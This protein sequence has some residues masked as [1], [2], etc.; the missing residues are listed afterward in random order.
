MQDRRAPAR[1]GEVFKQQGQDEGWWASVLA[2]EYKEM[3]VES[4][5]VQPAPQ[6]P[7]SS[8]GNTNWERAQDLFT[9]DEVVRL[10]VYGF[11]HGG[12]LVQGEQI[13]GFVPVSH[14]IDMACSLE[15]D[16]R[17]RALGAYVSR[18]LA[19][20]I[21]ECEPGAERIVLSERAALA[22]E[23]RRRELFSSLHEG[24]IVFGTVTNITDFGVFADLGG[25]EGLIHV[26]ELSWGRVQH[27]RD[28]LR[29]GEEVRALVLAVSEDNGRV[30]LSLKRLCPN[31]W[32]TMLEKHA[33]GDVV[34]ATITK[35]V[36]FGAFAR[37]DE[38]V[39]GLIHISA[40]PYVENI[41]HPLDMLKVGE[42]VQVRILHIDGER[43]RLGLGLILNT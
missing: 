33:P 22:G 9:R 7:A 10:E 30:A 23:G 25:L 36:R 14:L 5:A 21:I 27:P 35:I 13:K 32:E 34:G 41:R 16:E 3:P 12:L 1:E 31:P 43:R 29:V 20:K 15:V 26:S 38:G 37:L 28:V 18:T 39:E 8:S 2:D 6:P 42:Q 24:E 17:R 4:G 19:L 40:I 11:N